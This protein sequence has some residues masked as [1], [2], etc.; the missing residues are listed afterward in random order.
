MSMGNKRGLMTE[1]DIEQS[2]VKTVKM[3][4]GTALSIVFPG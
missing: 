1:K 3:G 4:G 2:F